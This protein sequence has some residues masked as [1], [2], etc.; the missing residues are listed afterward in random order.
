MGINQELILVGI[1]HKRSLTSFTRMPK[2][3]CIELS[4]VVEVSSGKCGWRS[5]SVM[6]SIS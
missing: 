5:V 1:H 6:T 3:A 4:S 2:P